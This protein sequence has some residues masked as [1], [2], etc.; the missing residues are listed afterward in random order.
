LQISVDIL[1][2][3][4]EA[5]FQDFVQKI[6]FCS[7]QNGLNWRNLICDMKKDKPYFVVT[8]RNNEITG[9]LPLYFFKSKFGNVLTSNAYN[10]I[11]G[12][13][14]SSKKNSEQKQIHEMLLGYSISLAREMDCSVLTV[15]TNPFIDDQDFYSPMQPDYV[16]ENFVQYISMAEIFDEKGNFRHPNYLNRT[17]LSRNL[18]KLKQCELLIS[19]EQN[20]EYLDQAFLLQQKRMREL[21]AHQ[22]PR[23]FFDSALKNLSLK[24][25]GKF[26]FVFYKE[27]IIAICLFLQGHGLLDVYMLCMDSD[28]KDF[29][30]NF[31]ITKYLL[32]YAYKNKVQLI[33][34][35]SSPTRGDGVYRWKGQWGSRERT[36][37]YLTRII[38]DVS[39]W[40]E[41]SVQELAEAYK[42]H[43]ILP[44]NALNVPRTPKTSKTPEII[45]KDEVTIFIRAMQKIPIS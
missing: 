14:C 43:Y 45:T 39:I 12:I 41:L 4:E 35:M 32:E 8:K 38:G 3:N 15:G 22:L 18:D 37:R 28:F 29:R 21:G 30:P 10:T 25:Q 33:N 9:A 26:L 36:F 5:L 6:P 11:S 34:W 20:Q 44:F 17:N 24:H 19:E 42:F 23:V 31:A 27:R 7:V 2:K 1:E 40:R 13:Q 16:L